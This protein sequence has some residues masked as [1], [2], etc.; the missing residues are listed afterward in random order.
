MCVVWW[1]G[2]QAALLEARK[3]NVELRPLSHVEVVLV[4]D[5]R[6]T[7]EEHVARA[8]DV[9]SGRRLPGDV[10]CHGLSVVVRH[11]GYARYTRTFV[12]PIA[13]AGWHGVLKDL[14]RLIAR[15]KPV[16]GFELLKGARAE[17]ERRKKDFLLTNDFGR[18]PK[19]MFQHLGQYTMEDFHSWLEVFC[20]YQ[21]GPGVLD[22]TIREH[23]IIAELVKL[24]RS[25]LLRLL[26]VQNPR[27]K[28]PG[29]AD[30]VAQAM[31]D[32]LQY[33][34]ILETEVD[35]R[36]CRPNLHSLLCRAAEQER[37][38]GPLS[39]EAEYWVEAG[40]QA[41]KKVAA[42]RSTTVP[43]AIVVKA[44]LDQR[45]LVA[46]ANVHPGLLS[47]DACINAVRL[48]RFDGPNPDEWDP[49]ARED[50]PF[51]LGSGY[52]LLSGRE[53]PQSAP[54]RERRMAAEAAMKSLLE[55]FPH[56][57]RDDGSEWRPANA[58]SC[59]MMMYTYADTPAPFCEVLH[60]RLY[61]HNRTRISYNVLCR[62]TEGGARRERE[63]LYVCRIDFFVKATLPGKRPLRFVVGDLFRASEVDGPVGVYWEVN[64]RGR[65]DY[66]HTGVRFDDIK[67]K[68]VMA[69]PPDAA[70]AYVFL[71]SRLSGQ[72]RGTEAE[73]DLGE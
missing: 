62:Y 53:N 34:T 6:L 13:H 64:Y 14:V 19:C 71:Y 16:G 63:V 8:E 44:T 42:G 58:E 54:W 23:A 38:R 55:E 48:R 22:V 59:S 28:L 66:Q 20:L 39:G 70:V 52:Q 27:K 31:Q 40:V 9:R 3:A 21:L 36:M 69:L 67:G 45:A 43:A 32:L 41:C 17:A 1:A 18:P 73:E 60:S 33:A 72:Q 24:L 65:P 56:A 46:A 26:K 29:V 11:V 5:K 2:E 50:E 30:T 7:H 4:G 61:G 35:P 57:A 68:V 10:G 47:A 12:L 15:G 37:C 25:S 49:T 51:L